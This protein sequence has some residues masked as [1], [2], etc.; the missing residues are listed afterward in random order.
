MKETAYRIYDSE[1]KKMY[2]VDRLDFN[3]EGEVI[4]IGHSRWSYALSEDKKNLM[5]Y[6]GRVDMRGKRI[7]EN[8]IVRTIQ[9]P[10]TSVPTALCWG[11][12]EYDTDACA[13]IARPTYGSDF[14]G[15]FTIQLQ[16]VEV[17]GNIYENPEL[18]TNSEVLNYD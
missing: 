15:S 4:G 8:D 6:I 14:L 3:E 1:E 18:L 16:Y 13:Y 10:M 5:Q 2:D 7:F 12:V 9:L 11:V 17:I